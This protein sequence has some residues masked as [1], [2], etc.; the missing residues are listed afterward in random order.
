MKSC[1]VAA[2]RRLLLC[3]P[4]DDASFSKNWDSLTVFD[5]MEVSGTKRSLSCRIKNLQRVLSLRDVTINFMTLQ[6]GG[7]GGGG[8]PSGRQWYSVQSL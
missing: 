6:S 2:Q 8:P 3:F 1:L 4:S 7:G 5:R